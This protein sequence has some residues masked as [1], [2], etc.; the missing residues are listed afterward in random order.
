MC[1][2]GKLWGSLGKFWFAYVSKIAFD[3]AL[4]IFFGAEIVVSK[5][6]KQVLNTLYFQKS[7]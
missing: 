4:S 2:F 5:L 3:Q 6:P 7:C 1:S